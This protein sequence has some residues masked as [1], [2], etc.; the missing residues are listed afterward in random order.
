MLKVRGSP[1]LDGG[2]R[3]WLEAK[4]HFAVSRVWKS[5]QRPA[6]SVDRV[7]RLSC[8]P[9]HGQ[10]AR[11]EHAGCARDGDRDRSEPE[12]PSGELAEQRD[13]DASARVEQREPG[14]ADDRQ[15]R[16]RGGEHHLDRAAGGE[17]Q[18][19]DRRFVRPAEPAE[20]RAR[21]REQHEHDRRGDRDRPACCRRSELAQ[22]IAVCSRFRCEWSDDLIEAE[23]DRNEYRGDLGGDCVR[24]D[25]A[26]R[27]GHDGHRQQIDAGL[28]A[29]QEIGKPERQRGP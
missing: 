17:H 24:G 29:L 25:G 15:H 3:G 7:E 12:K 14:R 10:R 1:T 9:E 22:P 26:R 21:K 16:G 2:D 20:Q 8:G 28:D 4:H 11:S 27:C 13:R 6:W 18:Q 19:H 23:A 5:G